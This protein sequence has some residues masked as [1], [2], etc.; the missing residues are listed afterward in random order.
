MNEEAEKEKA[1]KEK[2]TKLAERA[3]L[4][5][6]SNDR[7]EI[8]RQVLC[9]KKTPKQ[10]EEWLTKRNAVGNKRLNLPSFESKHEIAHFIR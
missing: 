9:G 5:R 2:R 3:Y 7:A 1:E 6:A 4:Q 8:E 10:A